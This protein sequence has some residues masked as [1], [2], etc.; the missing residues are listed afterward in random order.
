MFYIKPC[1]AE[2][3]PG[4]VTGEDSLGVVGN[5]REEAGTSGNPGA[6]IIRYDLDCIGANGEMVRFQRTLLADKQKEYE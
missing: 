4:K 6:T 2:Q 1:L 3:L 5:D